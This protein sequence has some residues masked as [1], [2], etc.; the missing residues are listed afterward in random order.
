M[1]SLIHGIENRIQM[2]LFTK[3]KQTHIDNKRM[4][5]K[6]QRGAGGINWDW[7]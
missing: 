2:N 5:T 7:D 1:T 3:Q 4:A 6:M